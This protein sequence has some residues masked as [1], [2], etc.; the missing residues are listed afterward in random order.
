MRILFISLFLLIFLQGC[1]STGERHQPA[2]VSESGEKPVPPTGPVERDRQVEVF[3]YRAPEKPVFQPS[4]PVLALV[5]KAEAQ[6]AGGDLGG[7]AATLERALRIEPRNPHLLNK[8]AW[9]RLDQGRYGQAE[10]LAAKSNAL[11]AGSSA[12]QQDNQRVIFSARKASV[13]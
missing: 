13:R 8:L 7:A 3:A 11:A 12:L 5:D 10:S 6:K 4:R 2:P 9:V 1:L